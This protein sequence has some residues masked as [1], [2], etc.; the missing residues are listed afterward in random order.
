MRTLVVDSSKCSGCRICGLWC[1]LQHEQAANPALPRV[2]VSRN[3]ARYQCQPVTSAPCARPACIDACPKQALNQDNQTGGIIVDHEKCI[4]CR[5]CLR[6]CPN[7]AISF[8]WVSSQ[9]IDVA[10]AH[11][12]V[13]DKAL[14]TGC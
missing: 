13:L 12:P 11:R 2:K 1:S 6:T 8:P 4:G 3:H 5:K 14:H 9:Y 10:Y 7:A